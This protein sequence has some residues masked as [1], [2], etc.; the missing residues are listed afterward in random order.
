[1]GVFPNQQ[2][3]IKPLRLSI[4]AEYL[5]IQKEKAVETIPTPCK[6]ELRF[7]HDES[8]RELACKLSR[9]FES[10]SF[11]CETIRE[12]SSPAK[13][14]R[15]ESHSDS[16][17]LAAMIYDAFESAG[18]RATFTSHQRNPIDTIIIHLGRADVL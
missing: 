7:P 2:S 4:R 16:E 15:V 6:V 1:M 9:V 12:L 18:V 3:C 17:H 11:R 5:R 8:A 14:V 10:C 13:G